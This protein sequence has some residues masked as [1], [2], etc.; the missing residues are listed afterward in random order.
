MSPWRVL[1]LVDVAALFACGYYLHAVFGTGLPRVLTLANYVF[2]GVLVLVGV[3]VLANALT[4][5]P[6][7]LGV[8]MFATGGAV[9]VA[10]L[11]YLTVDVIRGKR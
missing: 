10:F 11:L 5:E 8:K 6:P 4:A 7:T 1:A 9:A 3:G 2:A